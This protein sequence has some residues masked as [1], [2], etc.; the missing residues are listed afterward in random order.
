MVKYV[1]KTQ[2]GSHQKWKMHKLLMV[3]PTKVEFGGLLHHPYE[4]CILGLS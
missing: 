4:I 3:I 1:K 2:N